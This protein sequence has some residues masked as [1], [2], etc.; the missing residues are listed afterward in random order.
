MR[1]WKVQHTAKTTSAQ[2][3]ALDI[4]AGW[5]GFT[6]RH[7]AALARFPVG[8]ILLH[9]V[10]MLGDRCVRF[11]VAGIMRELRWGP[12]GLTLLARACTRLI[13]ALVL[14]L[15]GRS[16]FPVRNH[17]SIR[18]SLASTRKGAVDRQSD[19]IDLRYAAA[20]LLTLARRHAPSRHLGPLASPPALPY[21]SDKY[22][23]RQCFSNDLDRDD[24]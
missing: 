1:I 21:A 12:A 10:A 18:K 9:L 6:V 15:S 19:P 4:V 11:H 8:R 7:M 17:A 5:A 16:T 20:L 14:Y 13:D 22:A 2:D 3:G 23:Y 24:D